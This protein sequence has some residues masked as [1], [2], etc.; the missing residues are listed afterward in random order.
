MN[1]GNRQEV[2]GEA[3]RF[4]I[5]GV[6]NTLI[7]FAI[8]FAL[9][10]GFDLHVAL[11]NV[12]AFS[13]AVINSFFMNKYWSFRNRASNL[14]SGRQLALFVAVNLGG[15]ALSTAT[16]WGLADVIP[17]VLAKVLATVVS[18]AWNF[19]GSRQLVYRRAPER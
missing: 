1:E 8:F 5:V 12:I 7:D 4:I 17:L 6:M 14:Q 16:V 11:A 13:V 3:L 19:I 10:L 15:M 2:V 18:F 9:V